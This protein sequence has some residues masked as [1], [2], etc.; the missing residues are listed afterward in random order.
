M[1]VNQAARICSGLSQ[2]CTLNERE[3]TF[4]P[5]YQLRLDEKALLNIL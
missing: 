1:M 5:L 4:L 2:R 3:A